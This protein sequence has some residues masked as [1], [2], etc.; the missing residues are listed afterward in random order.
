MELR[1]YNKE[2]QNK[3][4]ANMR[5]VFG[6]FMDKEKTKVFEAKQRRQ[7]EKKDS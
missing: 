4:E 5:A 3:H 1:F 7:Q 6:E 2:R